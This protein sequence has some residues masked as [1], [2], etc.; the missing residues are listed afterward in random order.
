MSRSERPKPHVLVRNKIAWYL[1][2]VARAIEIKDRSR[3]S[4]APSRAVAAPEPGPPAPAQSDHGAF[5]LKLPRKDA[6]AGPSAGHTLSI[7]AP[8]QQHV[9]R[10][11]RRDG[12]AGFEPDS[13][14]CL[15]A[16]LEQMPGHLFFD[17]GANIGVYALVATALSDWHTVAFEPTPE[18]AATASALREAN[19]LSFAVEQLAV[20]DQTRKAPLYLSDLTDSSNS[21]ARDYRPS[22]AS[23][24]VQVVTLDQYCADTGQWPDLLKVDTE[25]TEPAVFRGARTLLEGRQPWIICEV[26]AGRSEAQLMEL[27]EPFDYAWYQITQEERLVRRREIFGD[28]SFNFMNWLFAPRP[29]DD[30]FFESMAAWRAALTQC[31]A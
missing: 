14:A 26:L 20:G 10:L 2:R 13:L 22:S 29:P 11:L 16:I 12:L 3:N 24:D 28:R 19:S 15:L 8:R 18:L 1:R 6:S 30:A 5:T 31:T 25:S 27:F 9:P 4:P 17:I 21:L 7:T 23:I